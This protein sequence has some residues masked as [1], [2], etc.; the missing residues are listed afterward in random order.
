MVSLRNILALIPHINFIGDSA[1]QVSKL[2]PLDIGNQDPHVLM[3]VNEKNIALLEKVEA[4]TIICSKEFQRYKSNCNYLIV[5]N[6]R[7]SFKL[8]LENFFLPLPPLGISTSAM[9]HPGSLLGKDIYIGNF[10][11]IEEGCSIGNNTSIGHNTVILKN[12][13][14]GNNVKIGSNNT[15]GGVGFGYE[16]DKEGEFSLIPHI[17]NVVIGDQVEIGNNTCIDR[18]VI[19]STL[20]GENVKV[21]NLVHIAHGVIIGKNS[22]IIANAMI[23]GSTVIGENV[24][25]APSVSILNKKIVEDNAL[26]GMGA[27]VVKNVKAG[28]TIVG[29]PG[30]VLFSAQK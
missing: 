17:G 14:I 16:R 13:I 8:V 20:L 12:T 26:I 2:V 1:S 23:A 19:G 9:I 15:I 25:V 18:A 22:L 11:T 30:K 24:W 5:E 4:G 3:W 27:V 21:D 28:D 10:V 7:Y 29:N 6:P